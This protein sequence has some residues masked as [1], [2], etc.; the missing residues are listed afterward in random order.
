M[1]DIVTVSDASL[2]VTNTSW[3]TKTESIE[4]TNLI[5][6]KCPR[7]VMNVYPDCDIFS[8]V[9]ENDYIGIS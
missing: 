1:N 5:V 3:K 2:K 8:L 6:K 7:L 4:I 9:R